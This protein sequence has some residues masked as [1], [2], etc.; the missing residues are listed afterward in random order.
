MPA[1]SPSKQSPK[2]LVMG[3]FPV[4]GAVVNGGASTVQSLSA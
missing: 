3:V 2:R 4:R 1:L